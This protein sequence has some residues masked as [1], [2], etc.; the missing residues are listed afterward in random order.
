MTW[1]SMALSPCFPQLRSTTRHS[2]VRKR[3]S[4]Y[5]VVELVLSQRG[6]SHLRLNRITWSPRTPNYICLYPIGLNHGESRD[7]PLSFTDTT[8]VDNNAYTKSHSKRAY[9]CM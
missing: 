9:A 3:E 2:G 1:S 6:A 5:E 4:D 8:K 7:T